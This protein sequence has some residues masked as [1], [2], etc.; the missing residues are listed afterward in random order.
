M[1][2]F[3]KI[4]IVI[5]ILKM[6]FI[7]PQTLE[8]RTKTNE[9]NQI[10]ESWLK[11]FQNSK[12][13]NSNLQS[14]NDQEKNTN[15]QKNLLGEAPSFIN[16]FSKF[17]LVLLLFGI[18]LYFLVQYFKKKNLIVNQTSSPVK[19]LGSIPL[20]S[21]KYL[22]IIDLLGQIMIIGISE[23]NITLIQTVENSRIAEKIRL[24][25]EENQKRMSQT[26]WDFTEILN[27]IFGGQFSFWHKDQNL[28]KKRNFYTELKDRETNEI[29]L[30]DLE[31]LLRFQKDKLKIFKNTENNER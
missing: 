1:K 31:E 7:F 21:G 17:I 22:Q 15:T 9:L 6:S 14:E 11:E 30:E 3:K 26:S 13:Q 12:N 18:F 23:N 19:I 16:L 10:E 28:K 25:Y 4:F 5:L 20:M 29:F 24:W 8:K 27:K 2:N